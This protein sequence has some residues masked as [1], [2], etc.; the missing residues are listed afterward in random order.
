MKTSAIKIIKSWLNLLSVNKFKIGVSKKTILL[1]L[2]TL[3]VF[4]VIFYFVR[5][6]TF[7]YDLH[8]QFV[9]KQINSNFKIEPK[10][11]GDISYKFFPTPRLYFNEVELYFDDKKSNSIFLE[12]FYILLSSSN[13]GNIKDFNYK[14]F[15]VSKQKIKFNPKNIK[16]FIKFF[17][18]KKNK[19]LV[20]RDN[21]IFFINDQKETLSFKNFN[22]SQKFKKNKNEIISN[23][24]FS[25][26][27]I[28]IKFLGEKNK[29]KFFSLSIPKLDIFLDINFEPNS[30]I[31][32]QS[33]ELKFDLLKTILLINF[34]GNDSFSIKDSF[35]RNKFLNS[36]INGNIQFKNN[37][38]FNLNFD[39]NKV[40]LRKLL[41]YYFAPSLNSQPIISSI[42][43]KINGKIKIL[44]K[45]SNSFLGKINNSTA[46]IIFEN[47][48]V[49]INDA[50]ANLPFGSKID[51]QIEY[52]DIGGYQSIKFSFKFSSTDPAKFFRKF[53]IYDFSEKDISI[54]A[55]GFIDIN[56][57]K[58][59][60]KEIIKNNNERLGKKTL[61]DIEKSFN[62][63]VINN[64][65]LDIFDFFKIKRFAKEITY[66]E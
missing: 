29:K 33:G 63:V 12:N 10:I 42:S 23:S 41:Y 58:I 24:I 7:N 16:N 35:V 27:K 15:V 20:F 18:L 64:T 66:S 43:K 17:S 3:F 30:T 22:L 26:N 59:K 46:I 32:Y 54:L 5:P 36:K 8:R 37:F 48:D 19:D 4:F 44:N 38:Y 13:L 52:S 21:E 50:T 49:K 11:R 56:N 45:S 61:S 6:V 60:F 65:A 31:E 25:K 62:E 2:I 39:I 55:N 51:Y 53:D 47:G 57:N 34:N 28:N 9:E 40:A 14:K 1:G